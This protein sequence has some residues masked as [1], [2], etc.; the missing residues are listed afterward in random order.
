MARKLAEVMLTA[1]TI[2]LK[3]NLLYIIGLKEVLLTYPNAHY[4]IFMRHKASLRILGELEVN[5]Q[6]SVRRI[7]FYPFNAQAAEL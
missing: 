1:R 7:A 6:S 2:C 5:D 3:D 4:P